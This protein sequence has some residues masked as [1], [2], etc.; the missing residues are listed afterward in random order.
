MK[1][2]VFGGFLLLSACVLFTGFLSLPNGSGGG[3]LYAAMLIGLLIGIFGLVK[4]EN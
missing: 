3:L 4:K 1:Y 2:V